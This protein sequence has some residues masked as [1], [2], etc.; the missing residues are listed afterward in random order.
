MKLSTKNLQCYASKALEYA[1]IGLHDLGCHTHQVITAEIDHARAVRYITDMVGTI[2]RTRSV[3]FSRDE[4]RVTG[5]VPIPLGRRVLSAIDFD[6]AAIRQAFP[7][8]LLHPHV[9]LFEKHVKN[10]V[11]RQYASI[12]TSEHLLNQR[13]EAMRAEAKTR[14]FQKKR[15]RFVNYVRTNM[16][17]MLSYIDKLPYCNRRFVAVRLDLGYAYAEWPPYDVP[18]RQCVYR[19][20]KKH[21]EALL[22][23]LRN[24]FLI[25]LTWHAWKLLHGQHRSFHYQFLLLFEVQA[26]ETIND[27]ALGQS[28]GQLWHKDITHGIGTYHCHNAMSSKVRGLG[29]LNPM[30]LEAL[31]SLRTEVAP[32]LV[33]SDFYIR[34]AVGGG[35]TFDIG[36]SPDAPARRQR[37]LHKQLS[38]APTTQSLIVGAAI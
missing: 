11:P 2:V 20:V 37:S 32:Q 21:R 15:D 34:P 14:T 12:A 36:A 38:S 33:M 22:E 26:G 10:I 28:I 5:L 19:E 6:L 18:R 23:H 35:R 16:A 24:R 25:P 29:T 17:G 8:H 7:H 30:D 27:A 31:L 3:L 9:E 1:H 13:I 4:K